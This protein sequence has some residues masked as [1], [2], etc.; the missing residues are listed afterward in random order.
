MRVDFYQL[1][2]DPVEQVV[3]LLASKVLASGECLVILEGGSERRDRLSRA[4]WEAPGFLAHGDAGADGA[5]RQPILLA[6]AC[7]DANGARVALIADGEWREDVTQ[8]QRVLLLFDEATRQKARA[9][10]VKLGQRDE[11]ERHV[12]KQAAKGG[13]REV[14]DRE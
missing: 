13:W 5:E 4:L 9:L 11:I 12:F 14:K 6:K 8:Y 10:Y 1:S 7:T 3:L 2:R